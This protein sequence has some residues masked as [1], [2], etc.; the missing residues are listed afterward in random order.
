MLL[1]IFR[2]LLEVFRSAGWYF[3]NDD[4][5]WKD[6]VVGVVVVR[7]NA[8]LSSYLGRSPAEHFRASF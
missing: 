4:M 6:S 5:G 7:L 3:R 8:F 1:S 2:G